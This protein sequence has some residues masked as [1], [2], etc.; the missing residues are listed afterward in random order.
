MPFVDAGVVA[1][2]LV[3][4]DDAARARDVLAD[5]AQAPFPPPPPEA[6][7]SL[8]VRDIGTGMTV[9]QVT[10]AQA[11]FLVDQLE[12]EDAAEARYFIDAGTIEMLEREGA[13]PALLE[14]LRR[15]LG[16]QDGVEIHVALPG[17]LR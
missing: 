13:E 7:A 2:I 9:G 12:E 1:E 4:Q 11:R 10:E 14:T 5:L 6:V 17:A 16:S 15:V 3:R 8:D